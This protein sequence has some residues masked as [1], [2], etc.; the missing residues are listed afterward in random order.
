MNEGMKLYY[1][2]T[3]GNLGRLFY[4]SVEAQ[5]SQLK[6]KRILD[7]G[8]GFGFTSDFLAENN[9]VVAIEKDADMIEYAK[10][11]NDYTCVNAGLEGLRNF[12]DN[13]FDGVMCHLV[14]EFVTN[15][16]EILNELLRV[17]KPGGVLS[18]IRHNKNGRIVQAIVQDYDL[19]DAEKLLD[20]GY[21]YSSAFGDIR[22]YTNDDLLEW[23]DGKIA[24]QD[25]KGIRV[26]ASLHGAE[27]SAA[28]GWLENMLEIEGRLFN[29]DDFVKIAYF[30]HLLCVKK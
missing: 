25:V 9:T 8:S 28:D 20:G 15:Q 30:N 21:S 12:E 6:G 24:V 16:N 19:A 4:K 1:D 10:N 17:L 3:V 18:V 27:L 2:Y 29:N 22:Y 14:L 5:L 13:S 7:F 11:C 26:L 23:C